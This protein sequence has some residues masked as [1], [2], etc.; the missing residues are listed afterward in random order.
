MVAN[1]ILDAC[2]AL[3][4]LLLLIPCLSSPGRHFNRRK[5]ELL[6]YASLLHLF[7]LC[8]RVIG[9]IYEQYQ[10]ESFTH[11]IFHITAAVPSLISAFLLV[12]CI[13][14]DGTGR[15]RLPK[16]TGIPIA[17]ITCA[18]LP[19]VLAW[20]LEVIFPGFRFLGIGWSM[21]LNLVQS[22]VN[23]ENERLITKTEQRLERGQ[24]A[25]M[26]LQ[27]SPHFIFNTLS[28]IESLCHTSPEDAA[29]CIGNLSGYLRANIDALSSEELI[30]FDIEFQHIRQYIALEQADPARQFHFD[31]ELDVRSFRLPSLTVQPIV[32]NAVKHGALSHRDGSGRV[33]L[34][35]EAVGNYI[36]ITVTDNGRDAVMTESQRASSGIGIENTRKRLEA[37]CGGSL[38][39]TSASSGTKAVILIPGK[40]E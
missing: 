12:L 9:A 10:P 26:T 38:Q 2:A 3:I 23:A 21:A 36:R 11:R 29:E 5:Q 4:I 6:L 39:I 13:L 30:P 16:G 7:T 27:M 25:L 18:L 8:M 34:T 22:C 40:E 14:C 17:E 24:A 19:P 28:S 33:M 20:C 31:Y 37:L 15:I 35:T 1:I 32:E